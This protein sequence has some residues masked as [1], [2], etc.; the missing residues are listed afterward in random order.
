MGTRE[1]KGH[2]QVASAA[3]WQARPTARRWACHRPVGMVRVAVVSPP[4]EGW[5]AAAPGARRRAAAVAVGA[6]RRSGTRSL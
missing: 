1:M 4:Q 5:M 3:A 6:R 2:T